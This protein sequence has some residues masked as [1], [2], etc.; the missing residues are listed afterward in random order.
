M[1]CVSSGEMCLNMCIYRAALLQNSIYIQIYMCVKGD[2]E[3]DHFDD[4]N[5][6]NRSTQV[7]NG[8]I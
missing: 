4:S 6:L 7:S 8:A 1:T 3:K 5:N 2:I